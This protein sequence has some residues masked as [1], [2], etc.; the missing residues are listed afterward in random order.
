M[1]VEGLLVFIIVLL[2][3]IV[4]L[5]LWG[6][7]VK[8]ESKDFESAITKTWMDSGLSEKIGAVESHVKDIRDSSS[9]IEQMLR[10]PKER[11]SFGELSLETILSDQL[12]DNLY[13]VREKV[14]DGKIPDAHITSTVGTICIDSKFPLD[15]Y[16]KMSDSKSS[17]ERESYKKQFIKD[18]KRHLNKIARD[19]VCPDKGSAEF[20]FAYIPSEGIYY[21]LISEATEILRDY[22]KVGIQ[23]LSP[24][25]M[26]Q[27]IE[28][29]KAGVNAKKLSENAVKIQN[30]LV[31]LSKRFSEIDE[32][33][34]VFYTN[35]L[36][37]LEG[38]AVDLD[39][40]Y[41]KLRQEFE[42]ISK[43]SEK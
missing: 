5:L 20:A 6:K 11:A 17:E 7:K 10:V 43:F 31:G 40:A 9:D 18:V 25:T 35:H 19:Y 28:L 29:I 30:S 13:G 8:I 42:R 21:F 22:T 1:V 4:A 15:N 36:K 34:K 24:L 32:L 2:I 39:G 23:V 38:K 37:N 41:T 27:K 14:L 33:W 26:S 3:A 12:P 16:L